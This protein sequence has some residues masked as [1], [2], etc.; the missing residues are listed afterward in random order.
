MLD[1]IYEYAATHCKDIKPTTFQQKR[2]GGYICLDHD[3]NYES[4]ELV[5]NP[6]PKYLVS[7]SN[8]GSSTTNIIIEKL[9]VIV[10]ECG[11]K[12][13]DADYMKKA[14]IV[15]DNSSHLS[16]LITFLKNIREDAALRGQVLSDVVDSDQKL[17]N[18]L[19]S[20]K[21][22]GNKIE[23]D[24]SVING[25]LMAMPTK[26]TDII[27]IS[28]LSGEKKTLSSESVKFKFK[29]AGYD[30]PLAPF[31]KQ[32]ST[33]SYYQSGSMIARIGEDETTL[34]KAGLEQLLNDPK[35]YNNFFKMVHWYD[36]ESEQ[37][38]EDDELFSFT[39]FKSIN[40]DEENE[41]T[42]SK[43]YDKQASSVLNAV[44]HLDESKLGN[45]KENRYHVMFCY[46]PCDSRYRLYGYRVWN[47]RDV[48]NN[49]LK[50]KQDSSIVINGLD[51]GIDNLR[52][53]LFFFI[54]ASVKK[55][56]DTYIKNIFGNNI[57][58]LIMSAYEDTQI[59]DV[60]L[61]KAIHIASCY[62]AYGDGT[63]HLSNYFNAIKTIQLYLNRRKNGMEVTTPY[64]CGRIF[65][66]YQKLQ[67]DVTKGTSV[68]NL[69]TMAKEYPSRVL[70]RLSSLST[71]HFNSSEIKHTGKAIYY[72]KMLNELYA[73]IDSI[74]HKL[75]R[76]EQAEFILGYYHQNNTM[77]TKHNKGEETNE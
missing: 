28:Y 19:F 61:N 38:D 29:D 33:E 30:T 34:I 1:K 24:E 52:S 50:F 35:H 62:I 2:I 16:A 51:K 66:V 36:E 9:K 43:L 27:G 20:F 10:G 4:V 72:S 3:G 15:A 8:T 47:V 32:K 46:A 11:S 44:Q 57:E 31:S 75:T 5:E 13:R 45:I 40:E 21:I 17:K 71:H 6:E 18:D 26:E 53:Y 68:S 76:E 48:R 65:A 59:P 74:P 56:R 55:D 12:T 37:A 22:C 60:F 14:A 69:F 64:V 70:G 58:R 7:I 39:E 42:D 63:Y 49:L 41:N 54:P 25:M 77:Y 73:E 67:E 23:D